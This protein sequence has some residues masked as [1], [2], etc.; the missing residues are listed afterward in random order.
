[1]PK[2]YYNRKS[3]VDP[4]QHLVRS[5]VE[6][7][8]TVP[9]RVVRDDLEV[10]VEWY[11]GDVEELGTEVLDEKVGLGTNDLKRLTLGPLL[12]VMLLTG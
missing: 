5:E 12:L 11:G 7:D 4:F 1:M 2:G 8:L 3:R 9:M 10:I 6:L